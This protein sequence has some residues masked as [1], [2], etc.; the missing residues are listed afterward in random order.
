MKEEPANK[1][2][3]L[4]RA[5]PE[6][7]SNTDSAPPSLAASYIDAL[8]DA[9]LQHCFSFIG[10]GH[11]R[12]VA[13]TS[14]RFNEIYSIKHEKKTTLK[15]VVASVSSAELYLQDVT[16]QREAFDKFYP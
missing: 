2:R 13:G 3:R 6:T 10:K 11:Y 15:S 7:P 14:R 5:P 12:Y 4:E 16:E 1:R 8:P 9:V